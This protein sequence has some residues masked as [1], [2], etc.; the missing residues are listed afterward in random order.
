[1]W[2][3]EIKLHRIDL[4]QRYACNEGEVLTEQQAFNQERNS[5]LYQVDPEPPQIKQEQEKLCSSQEGEQFGL[6]QELDTFMMTYE[7][8]DHSEAEP[9]NEQLLSHGP[10]E[11]KKPAQCD[12][13]GKTFNRKYHL[14]RHLRIHTGKKPAESQDEEES[15]HHRKKRQSQRVGNA[16]VSENQSRTDTQKKPA[17]CDTCGKT[18]SRKSHLTRHLRIHTGEKPAESQDEEESQHHRKKRQSQRVGNAP[19]SENQSKTDTQ[20]KPAQCDT[21]GKTFNRKYHLTRHL[22]I[23]TGEKPFSCNTCGKRFNGK[24]HLNY[25]LRVHSDLQQQYVCK[26]GEVLTEQQNQERNSNLYQVVPEPPQIKQEQE[27][28]CSSQ[29]GEQLG[30]KQELDTFMWPYEES[31]HSEAE[32][33]NE[34]RLSHSPAETESQDMDERKKRQSQRVGNVPVSENQS[35]T[36]TQKKPAQCDTCGK[37]FSRKSHLIR[38]LRVHTGEKPFPCNTCGKRFSGKWHLDYHL[39]VHSDLQQ[40]YACNEGE[41]LTEQQAFNQERN[42]NLYQVD[43]EPPQIKQEQEKLCSSQE[44]EQLGLKQELD[45]FMMTYE[46]NDHSEAEPFNEQLLSHGPAEA[47]KPAQ[48]DTCGKTFNRKYHLTRHLRIHTGEKPAESQDE[49]ESQHHRKKRQSQ[50][51]GNAPVSENQSRTD[52]QKK[53]AQCDTCGKTFSRKY[54]LT[55]HLRIHTGEKPFSCN[56]CGKKFNGK[57]HLNYHLRVH[58]DLQQQYVCKEGEVL[59]AEPGEEQT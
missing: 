17:Q 22:R 1:M 52:T 40:R 34:Q 51:V 32:P 25:H 4:Q 7:E 47:K 26:E 45:T 15:Q 43:P 33:F 59:T 2:K 8:S 50:R 41:V 24:W 30:L 48:C 23:H 21:C 31:D 36:D 27:E 9:F 57:W 11:A 38:H 13:C 58:S 10:A 12:T 29:G 19:V 6:K 20:K 56:T 28:V 14:T 44:G 49:E 55:R 39:R 18:F 54:H 3:P 35:Q 53:P 5:N 42:T 16:P 46:E 37:I